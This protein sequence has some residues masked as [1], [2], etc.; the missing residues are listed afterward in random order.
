MKKYI[1]KNRNSGTEASG[2]TLVESLVAVSIFAVVMTIVGSLYVTALNLQRRAFNVQVTEENASFV[3]ETMVKEI[4]V[5]NISNQNTNCP[6]SSAASLSMVHP[7]NGSIVYSLSG[8]A[9]HRS[10]NGLDAQITSNNVQFTKLR[11]CIS[12]SNSNDGLQPRITILAS[13]K[14]SNTSQQSAID[15]QTTLSQRFLSN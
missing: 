11:F 3:L 8:G 15:F 9:V 12:G 4:R 1:F 6:S 10:V 5:S 7:V 14:S 13:V 2:F